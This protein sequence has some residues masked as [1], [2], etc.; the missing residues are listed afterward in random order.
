MNVVAN[1]FG[2]VSFLVFVISMYRETKKDIARLHMICNICDMCQYAVL[3]G[4]NGFTEAAVSLVANM[5][6]A[7]GDNKRLYAAVSCVRILL[8]CLFWEGFPSVLMVFRIVF[9]CVCML[10]LSEQWVRF[11]SILSQLIWLFYD[12]CFGAVVTAVSDGIS[13]VMIIAAMV[14]NRAG[15][16]RM[17]AV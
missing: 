7:K 2:F 13:V 3:H 14:K 8:V 16:G 6:Y 17:D 9:S 10:W 11:S 5:V 4:W 15:R 12:L 1:L